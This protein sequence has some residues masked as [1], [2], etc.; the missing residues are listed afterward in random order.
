MN[1]DDLGD[2]F[3]T[4]PLTLRIALCK[5]NTSTDKIFHPSVQLF[6]LRH[7]YLQT[8]PISFELTG[9]NMKIVESGSVTQTE[10]YFRLLWMHSYEMHMY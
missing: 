5:E 6:H 2:C 9:E 3:C 1:D 4:L 8:A 10:V 7:K